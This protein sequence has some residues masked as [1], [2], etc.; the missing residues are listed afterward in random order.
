MRKNKNSKT[1]S[2]ILLT[3]IS[4]SLLFCITTYATAEPCTICKVYHGPALKGPVGI[5]HTMYKEVYGGQLFY[6]ESSG[7][8]LTTYDVLRFDVN[9]G[10]DFQS[11]WGTVENFYN[12]V[13]I[14]GELLC[15]IYA[16]VKLIE[17]TTDDSFTPERFAFILIK[18]AIGIL[19]IRNGFDIV[20]A[21]MTLSTVAFNNLSSALVNQGVPNGCN[22]DDLKDAGFF[23]GL[24][25]MLKLAIPY[26]M[27]CVAK[28]IV[29]VVA[30]TRILDVIIRAIFAPI[31]IADFIYE[32]MHGHGFR[33]IKKLIASALQAVV[34]LAAA[35]GYSILASM[36]SATGQWLYTVILAYAM[37]TLMF[38][39]QSIAN[40]TIGA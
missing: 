33:Y 28:L 10:A 31:G 19:I 38:K 22:Y 30:W 37:I 17:M 32:G 1:L 26:F 3:I 15:Y 36:T 29:S 40:D 8:A 6:S 9:D 4:I 23:T 18:M 11:L 34:I 13:K 2:L 25:Q 5:A 39:T 20:T 7:G 27:M 21:G 12:I 14:L 35:R 16:M 24:G